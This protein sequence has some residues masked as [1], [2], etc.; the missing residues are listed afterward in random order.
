MVERVK[1]FRGLGIIGFREFREICGGLLVYGLSWDIAGFGVLRA[2]FR[3]SGLSLR[4]F[5]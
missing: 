5:Q 2:V 4:V 1:G 3:A